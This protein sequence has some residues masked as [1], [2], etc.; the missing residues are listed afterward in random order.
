MSFIFHLFLPLCLD[1]CYYTC[2]FARIANNVVLEHSYDDLLWTLQ[3]LL[4]LSSLLLFAAPSVESS[5][6]SSD[7]KNEVEKGWRVLWSCL[8]RCLPT[9]INVTSMVRIGLEVVSWYGKYMGYLF[10]EIIACVIQI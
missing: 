8:V 4:R 7:H 5:I 10:V 1:L 3:S 2:L 6:K 9:F